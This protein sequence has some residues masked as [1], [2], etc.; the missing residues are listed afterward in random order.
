MIFQSSQEER[1]IKKL[2]SQIYIRE[3]AI[4]NALLG[5]NNAHHLKAL[6]SGCL[7][8]IR[9][10]AQMISPNDDQDELRDGE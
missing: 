9:L 3:M 4:N 2:I 8:M 6:S 10:L 7:E 5:I 1:N